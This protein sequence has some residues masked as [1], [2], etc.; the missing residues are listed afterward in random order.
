MSGVPDPAWEPTTTLVI[1]GTGKVG[2]RV[3]VALQARGEHVRVASRNRGDIRFDWH[4]PSTYAPALEGTDAVFI[5]G[6]GSATD[7]SPLLT[8]LLD[9]AAGAGTRRAVL[10][11]ARAVPSSTSRSR[12]T[13]TAFVR[14][15]RRR[16]TS[17]G[18]R[19]CS[20]RSGG[21][22]TRT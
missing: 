22:P 15:A 2:R 10:L 17:P 3:A 5:V 7:W 21:E 4:D 14:R 16:A 18:G 19:P 20:T 13:S 11:S 12:I 6:P 1:G 8:H 9:V